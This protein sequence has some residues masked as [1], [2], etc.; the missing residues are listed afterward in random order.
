MM[1]EV[2]LLLMEAKRLYLVKKEQ[3]KIK[4]FV[5]MFLKE[6]RNGRG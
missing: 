6:I 4:C 3:L 1:Q 2:I 5:T